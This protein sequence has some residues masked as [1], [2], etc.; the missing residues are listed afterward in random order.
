MRVLVAVVGLWRAPWAL[1]RT[2]ARLR[3]CNPPARVALDVHVF[4]QNATRRA[5][6]RTAGPDAALHALEAPDFF[7]RLQRAY[8]ALDWTRWPH[9]LVLRP[10]V[11]LS[12]CVPVADACAARA[13][14]GVRVISGSLAR[15]HVFHNR[16]WDFAYLVC[17]PRFFAHWTVNN[18]TRTDPARVPPLPAGFTG[19]W[20]TCRDGARYEYMEN[21]LR[22]HA[23]HRVPVG[24]LDALGVVARLRR[25]H[26]PP[27]AKRPSGPQRWLAR[28]LHA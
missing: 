13:T 3:E 27:A 2:L 23:E 14:G 20:R 17:A 12:R 22:R 8:D 15:P 28:W 1:E 19:C 24:T 18:L 26:A 7:V 11:E 10:D 25:G 6:A 4:T 5:V 21:V 9:A 16:D